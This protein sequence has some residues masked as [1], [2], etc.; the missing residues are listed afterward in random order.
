MALQASALRLRPSSLVVP[1]VCHASLSELNSSPSLWYTLTRHA[2]TIGFDKGKL[3]FTPSDKEMLH[4]AGVSPLTHRSCLLSCHQLEQ[5]HNNTLATL[6]GMH[7]SSQVQKSTKSAST[8]MPAPQLGLPPTVKP[9]SDTIRWQNVSEK[10]IKHDEQLWKVKMMKNDEN[11][12]EEE[13][14]E[15]EE[16]ENMMMMMMMMMM[17]TD[18]DWWWLM[19]TDDDWWWLMM[20]DDDWWWLMMTDDDWWW[21][22]MTDDDWWW[23]MM[24][25]DDWWWLMMTDDDWWWL[26]M[27]DDDWWWHMMTDDDWWWLMMTDD[28]IWWHMMTYD[29]I[30]W[31]MMTYDDIW[32]HM[33]T[34]DDIWWHMMTYDDIWWHMMTYDDIW[35]HM[36]KHDDIWWHMMT[37]DETWWNMMKHDETW[38]N[39]MKHDDARRWWIWWWN[40]MM[41]YDKRWW[42]MMED[43]ESSHAQFSSKLSKLLAPCARGQRPHSKVITN[44]VQKAQRRMHWDKQLN[45]IKHIHCIYWRP[46]KKNARWNFFSRH[47]WR[48][49]H[50]AKQFYL[51]KS[52]TFA[53]D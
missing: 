45:T 29:D 44:K 46:W 47:F 5:S 27:T 49:S 52:K 15:E 25:D 2:A 24:T 17:M 16:E 20:T 51:S 39:M 40:M 9:Y 48:S 37:Y 21:L 42:K 18:D 38:W 26:M 6:G 7:K 36:M 34:Y 53:S 35:W 43:D 23:L 8:L 3:C 10:M 11:D 12:K 4:M 14:E 50:L 41:K 33:M 1:E 32:W 13:E 28:D 30:W 22:M 19:M 31:H